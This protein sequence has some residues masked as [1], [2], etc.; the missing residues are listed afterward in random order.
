M[1]WTP[2]TPTTICCTFKTG[3]CQSAAARAQ[4]VNTW[5]KF[6]CGGGWAFLFSTSY[7]SLSRICRLARICQIR[8]LGN[9]TESGTCICWEA[10]LKFGSCARF[11]GCWG[12]PASR[13]LATRRCTMA[14]VFQPRFGMRNRRRTYFLP[15]LNRP[16]SWTSQE[17]WS[18]ASTLQYLRDSYPWL[19]QGMEFSAG[20]PQD[21][22]SHQ[23]H[24]TRC[25]RPSAAALV[26][27]RPTF[28][29]LI[30]F[31]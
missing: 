30:Q 18:E 5:S 15:A 25:R 27:A 8:C 19:A 23:K 10:S 31:S 4:E 2:S 28:A 3:L 29:T 13:I 14:V 11:G 21:N 17:N 7:P 26:W 22:T 9:K 6:I 24:L 12:S 20:L 1:G 16:S